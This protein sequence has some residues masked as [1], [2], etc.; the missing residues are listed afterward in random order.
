M[1]MQWLTRIC[2]HCITLIGKLMN[3]VLLKLILLLANGLMIL[4]AME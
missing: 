1:K 4:L 3:S 2:C